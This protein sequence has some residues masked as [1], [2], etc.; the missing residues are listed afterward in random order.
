M[1]G[2]AGCGLLIPQRRNQYARALELDG[3]A[4]NILSGRAMELRGQ[5]NVKIEEYRH[6]QMY[7]NT[8]RDQFSFGGLLGIKWGDV[9]AGSR[10]RE[11]QRQLDRT[12]LGEKYLEGEICAC[13]G[14]CYTALGQYARAMQ[15]H[16]KHLDLALE[17][18]DKASQAAACNDL[19][20]V[21][22]LRGELS[23][24]ARILGRGLALHQHVERD[25]GPHDDRRMS[26]F[27]LQQAA[28]LQLQAVLLQQGNAKWALG[29]C[30]QAKA[31]A[32]AHRIAA[33]A[34]SSTVGEHPDNELFE[35]WW[36]EARRLASVEG[37]A[38][39]IVEFSFLL[40]GTLAIWVM[41]GEGELITS[42]VVP[43]IGLGNTK[44]QTVQQLLQEA[45]GSMLPAARGRDDMVSGA[46]DARE[47]IG[48]AVRGRECAKCKKRLL[49]CRCKELESIER[50]RSLLRELFRVLIEPVQKDLAGAHELL[51][52][53]H[54][55]LFEVP[56]AA[57]IDSNG[58]YLIKHHALRVA[59]S[60]RVA[61]HCADAFQQEIGH[62]LVIGNPWPHC[63]SGLEWNMIGTT[64]P[65]EGRELISSQLATAL[66][67]KIHTARR[68]RIVFTQQ[69]WDEFGIID[70]STSD[71]VIAGDHYFK[72]AVDE[73]KFAE[74]E[75]TR[76]AEML[77]KSVEV[78]LHVTKDATCS[79]V[80]SEL[81]GTRWA[82]LACHGDQETASLVLAASSDAHLGVA[83]KAWNLSMGEV[84]RSV[85]LAK[86]ASVVLSACN[87]G[88]GE[89][90]AEGVVGLSRGFFM[91]GAACTVVSLWSVNDESTAVLMERM[92]Q[93]LM[94]GETVPCS[95]RL[96]ML[97][98][99][100][101]NTMMLRD[102]REVEYDSFCADLGAGLPKEWRRPMHWA[103]FLVVGAST[104]L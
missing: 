68:G 53:P 16:Q 98:L 22:Q 66:S 55:E 90:K 32:L 15:L 29:V 81:Q 12:F 70:L 95:L 89:I 41:T 48:S 79:K 63:V 20:N 38:V 52:I 10:A 39:R 35:S 61:R 2:M 46:L 65:E 24:A 71:F 1:C 5:V 45:R 42:V 97:S 102:G 30:S 54:K 60:L 91:A 83:G 62:A 58:D 93:H 88:R 47:G 9:S 100:Q 57:L 73:L 33:G 17:A 72:P 37:S 80:K 3:K 94:D 28:Y 13:L 4:S 74:K 23:E 11:L 31:R 92:Y 75:A 103:G 14:H 26:I 77:R 50:E 27:E 96:A 87:S 82:H 7:G 69:E 34:A 84:Q 76:V 56:W 99:A 19:G 36:D 51:I 44:G 21:L 40:N 64:R 101:G 8:F 43:S 59:P 67:G 18:G 85:Q 86:G 6:R 104:K 78:R 49:D 25:I